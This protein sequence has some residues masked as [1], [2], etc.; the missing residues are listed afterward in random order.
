M[1]FQTSGEVEVLVFDDGHT[2]IEVFVTPTVLEQGYTHIGL[3]VDDLQRFVMR[4]TE[5]GLECI[6]V[7]RGDKQLHFV[8]DS[9]GNLFEI[10][11]KKRS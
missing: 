1:I 2:K 9:S 5:T 7:P 4:C 3:E 10:T 6:T 11:E 8:R